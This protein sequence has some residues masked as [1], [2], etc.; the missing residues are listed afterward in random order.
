MLGFKSG[1]VAIA[2][3]PNVGKSTL[4]NKI[5]GEKVAITSN[6]PQTTRNVIKAVLTTE[7]SQVVFLDTPGLHLPKTKLGE[8]MVNVAAG[9]LHEVDAIVL[10]IE[11][12]D[13]KPGK[14]NLNAIEIIKK[15]N[16]PVYLVINKIDLVQKDQLLAVIAAYKDLYE[17]KAIIPVSARTGDGLDVLLK[18]IDAIL[19]KG[20]K[21]FPDD[22]LTDQPERNI[23]SELIRE[24]I[25]ISTD[26][27]VPHGTGIEIM[28]YKEKSNGTIEIQATIYCEKES[29]KGIL[30]GKNGSML[31]KIG[32]LARHDI[33][34]LLG[35]KVFLELWV[36][37]KPDWR[38][39][40]GFIKS[41]GYFE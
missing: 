2:G 32:T 10:L 40:D 36:K 16:V 35:T 19:L 14:G 24:K 27:E 18:E 1:F 15:I 17:F 11:A 21:F 6:K 38:N 12:T 30:I 20:P 23:V 13:L 28:S 4:L 3:R 7:K 33:E 29:H 37:V 31:K 39:K 34:D 26:E 25:L 41:L 9:T 5:C 8:Y 22:V